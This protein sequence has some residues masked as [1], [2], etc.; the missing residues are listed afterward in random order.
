MYLNF[1]F[2]DQFFELSC[3]HTHTHRNTH[4]H[5]HRHTDAHK[6]ADEFS[7]FCNYNKYDTQTMI[8]KLYPDHYFEIVHKNHDIEIIPKLGY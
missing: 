3:K 5:T 6:D 1:M 8:L 4:M 7:V 2:L